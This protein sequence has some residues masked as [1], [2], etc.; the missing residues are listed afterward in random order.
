MGQIFIQKLIFQTPSGSFVAKNDNFGPFGD[1]HGVILG[2]KNGPKGIKINPNDPRERFDFPKRF[3]NDVLGA[4]LGSENGL[5]GP[6]G[7]SKM[8]DF[9]DLVTFA[10]IFVVLETFFWSF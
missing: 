2:T 10:L 3:R 5:V 1:F 4:I 9:N 6:P 7:G 8:V